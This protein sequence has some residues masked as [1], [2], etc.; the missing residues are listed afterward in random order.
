MD[1]LSAPAVSILM[2]V[3]NGA[4]YLR[5]AIDS[6][7]DQDFT[8]FEFVI[9]DDCSSD[10]T[11]DIIEGYQDPRVV[12]IRNEAN[13]G[14]TAS[15][16]IA[17]RAARAELVCRIDADDAFMEG[18]LRRQ[19]EFMEGNPDVAVCGTA[20][21][22]IDAEGRDVSVN[23]LPSDALDIRFR[24]IRTVPVVHVSVMM[25]RSV[26][27]AAGGYPERYRFAAD[28]AL[29]SHL[30]RRGHRITN[31]PEVLTKYR[32]LDSTFGAAQKVGAA[33]SEAAEIIKA[34]A[35]ALAGVTLTEP[36]ARG[37]AL[38][39]FPAAGSSAYD[40]CE[41]CLTLRRIASAVYGNPPAGVRG[42]LIGLLFWSVTKRFSYAPTVAGGQPVAREVMQAARAFWRAPAILATLVVAAVV[43]PL[44]LSRIVATKDFL[45][46]RPRR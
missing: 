8:D 2:A 15:L 39:Y 40:L 22:R 9:V 46:R 34:N 12:Y 19:Y 20:A 35:E 7:M 44:G 38:L 1:P 17:L 18:K 3:Y 10:T 6:V 31:L 21:M 43:A 36:Q 28:Y 30:L 24:A 25:R 42:H 27:L 4:E 37:I 13:L 23:R 33:G 5:I 41:A 11:R 14:Q 45:L 16:N 26:I 32:E 29:W